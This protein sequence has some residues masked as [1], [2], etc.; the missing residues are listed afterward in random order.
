MKNKEN[1]DLKS[2]PS[3]CK[4]CDKKIRNYIDLSDRVLTR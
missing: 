1:L 4:I 2:E 3:L